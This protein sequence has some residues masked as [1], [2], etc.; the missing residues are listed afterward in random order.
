MP[1]RKKIILGLS[2]IAV[3]SLVPL[4]ASAYFSGGSEASVDSG[5]STNGCMSTFYNGWFWCTP[6]LAW[7]Y[8]EFTEAARQNGLSGD[9]INVPV[10]PVYTQPPKVAGDY[11]PSLRPPPLSQPEHLSTECAKYSSGFYLSGYVLVDDSDGASHDS[12][13]GMY[14]NARRQT[15]YDYY[16]LYMSLKRSTYSG[17]YLE[18]NEEIPN[19]P[20][21]EGVG[22]ISIVPYSTVQGVWDAT[23][24]NYAAAEGAST[25]FNTYTYFCAGDLVK[26]E[27]YYHGHT[28]LKVN[29]G[30]GK[31]VNFSGNAD[32][33]I[34]AH[35]DNGKGNQETTVTIEGTGA[36]TLFYKSYGYASQDNGTNITDNFKRHS[37]SRFA[38]VTQE[39]SKPEQH[40]DNIYGNAEI[41][42]FSSHSQ[43]QTYNSVIINPGE[44]VKLCSK[45]NF[46]R[47]FKEG[48][49][50]TLNSIKSCITVKYDNTK[51]ELGSI[52]QLRLTETDYNHSYNAISIEGSTKSQLGSKN[53]GSEISGLGL[54]LASQNYSDTAN[55]DIH[56]GLVSVM[57][58]NKITRERIV[59]GSDTSITLRGV[60]VT[61]PM[62]TSNCTTMTGDYADC[63]KSTTGWTNNGNLIVF[64]QQRKTFVAQTKHPAEI[65]SGQ[66]TNNTEESS[67]ATINATAGPIQCTNFGNKNVGVNDVVNYGRIVFYGSRDIKAGD[68][69]DGQW[70]GTVTKWL[71]PYDIIRLDFYGCMGNQILQDANGTGIEQEYKVTS[72]NDTVINR[73][74]YNTA[75]STSLVYLPNGRNIEARELGVRP[76]DRLKNNYQFYT[77]S[78][79]ESSRAEI[80]GKIIE[81]TF[82]W[83]NGTQGQTTRATLVFKTPFNYALKASASYNGGVV[84]MGESP[85]FTVNV[86]VSPRANVPVDGGQNAY[87]TGKI[88]YSY[89]TVTKL[90]LDSDVT[91]S[92]IAGFNNTSR[93]GNLTESIG[94]I[95]NEKISGK[96]TQVGEQEKKEGNQPRQ[97]TAAS[98]VSFDEVGNE[99]V[100]KKLCVAVAVFPS[101][102]HNTGDDTDITDEDQTV[103]LSGDYGYGDDAKT[104]FSL[105]CAT[106]GK[107]PTTSIEGGSLMAG[108]Q[109]NAN[110]T[111]YGGEVFGSWSEYGLLSSGGFGFGSG[112]SYGGGLNNGGLIK[113]QT[114]G[115]NGAAANSYGSPSEAE[116]IVKRDSLVA[117]SP[118]W[119]FAAN[120]RARYI[121]NTSIDDPRVVV[122]RDNLAGAIAELNSH[123]NE[124]IIAYYEHCPCSS[125]EI[126]DNI[127]NTKK[128]S[129]LVIYSELDI[130]IAK[131]VERVDAFLIADNSASVIGEGYVVDPAK[132]DT[133]AGY[134][135]YD[136]SMYELDH[137][138]DVNLGNAHL[139]A[140]CST[141]LR[142]NGAVATREI[143]LDR[144]YGGGSLGYDPATGD[145][146]LDPGTLT[147]RAEIFSYDPRINYWSYELTKKERNYEASYTKELTPRF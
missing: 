44:T 41:D 28:M 78:G 8:Y 133:C 9:F 135:E 91:A 77:E 128:N 123:D 53:F 127:I 73:L 72:N 63:Y 119:M 104:L 40:R 98:T 68:M 21:P 105:S 141:P 75:R 15:W 86:D 34:A 30:D 7:Y 36:K 94:D 32:Y 20:K 45:N 54:S 76:L 80:T 17:D 121:D 38:L 24:K 51:I 142:I 47:H 88:K 126:N 143:S 107:K 96:W 43:P 83:P 101:D 139:L 87:A 111:K 118:A 84:Y 5:G 99:A 93:N 12:K 137:D 131:N 144:A 60:T 102:S 130:T 120:I 70:K 26:V 124:L 29:L 37:V 117:T 115:N 122:F 97:I 125:V 108:G 58:M 13:V 64:P 50:D 49:W 25:N 56:P 81:N 132:I 92:D 95:L 110:Q 14:R 116:N 106:V 35:S 71:K 69:E 4:K 79:Q 66:I 100:G 136:G 55:V 42:N 48:K 31:G 23:A 85:E 90:Y 145:S 61:N 140:N 16:G 18:M 2:I 89:R 22:K 59:E 3:A 52:S 113:P 138:A 67:T 74:L 146:T 109:V 6:N 65:S 1:V 19:A 11:H 62:N 10:D 27:N 134:G 39:G 147:E 33:Q 46:Y 103:A 112:A 129:L 114:I 57:A 82:E